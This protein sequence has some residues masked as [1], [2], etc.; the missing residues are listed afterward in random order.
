MAAGA[1]DRQVWGC[2]GPYEARFRKGCITGRSAGRGRI[3][4]IRS[5]DLGRLPM[6]TIDGQT[7]AP[8]TSG[9]TLIVPLLPGVHDFEIRPLPQ[10]PIWRNWQ[11]WEGSSTIVSGSHR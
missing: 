9:N 8:G 1:G 2:E 10:P 5:A 4:Y 6:L 7:Y 3:L 11:Q